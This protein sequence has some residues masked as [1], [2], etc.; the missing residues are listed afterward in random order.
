M[1]KIIIVILALMVAG[2]S[3]A[4]YLYTKPVA[5]VSDLKP[6]YFI[7]APTLFDEFFND[8][9]GA[10][11]KY[12]G[13]II[14][15]KGKLQVIKTDTSGSTVFLFTND[16]IFG[17]NCGLSEGQQKHFSKYKAGD[18]ITI[19]GECVGYDMDV[20]MTRCVIME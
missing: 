5:D 12:L 4:Y 1:K 6:A 13:K 20:V 7:D 8:E 16:E 11:N 10:N 17:I 18:P 14:E 3:I 2:G 15:V 19:R 9:A